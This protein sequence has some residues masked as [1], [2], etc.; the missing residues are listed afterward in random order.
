M[1]VAKILTQRH[2]AHLVISPT[3]YC[4]NVAT[5][6]TIA[7]CLGHIILPPSQSGEGG[8]RQGT[9]RYVLQRTK[10]YG[11]RRKEGFWRGNHRQRV[12]PGGSGGCRRPA[13]PR[14]GGRV[15][16]KLTDQVTASTR[17]AAIGD[18]W[19]HFA[20]PTSTCPHTAVNTAKLHQAT[21]ESVGVTYERGE[22][23][24]FAEQR[25]KLEGQH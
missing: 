18:Q 6:D 7:L 2:T 1:N 17:R 14:Y 8:Y 22:Q 16:A 25:K 20:A 5:S 15:R 10:M 3:L 21:Q 12:M 23:L 11:T 13:L 4:S 24:P 9:K 19:S